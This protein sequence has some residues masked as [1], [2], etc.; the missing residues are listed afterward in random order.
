[1]CVCVVC[2]CVYVFRVR[3]PFYVVAA[4]R[5]TLRWHSMNAM[6]PTK[7]EILQPRRGRSAV[8]TLCFAAPQPSPH[9]AHDAR[10]NTPLRPAGPTMPRGGGNGEKQCYTP[11]PEN[12][13]VEGG[14]LILEARRGSYQGT[15]DVRAS[16]GRAFKKRGHRRAF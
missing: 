13:R 7:R 12:V 2:V 3:P 16:S 6:P 5:V 15:R 14:R 11:R 8:G 9:Y 1:M 4:C 10:R